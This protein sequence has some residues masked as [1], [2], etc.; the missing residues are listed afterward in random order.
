MANIDVFGDVGFSTVTREKSHPSFFLGDLDLFSTMNVDNRLIFLSEIQIEGEESRFFP[1]VERFWIGYTFNDLIT[2]RAGRHHTALGYWNNAYHHGKWLF[3]TVDRPFFLGFEDKNGVIPVHLIGIEME[4]KKA[5]DF[6]R[7]SYRFQIANGPRID[8][9][10]KKLDP[11]N[12]ADD[13]DSKEAAL[14]FSVTPVTVPDFIFGIS[15]TTYTLDTS[16]KAGLKESIFGFDLSYTKLPW[17]FLAEYFRFYNSD[18]A[19]DA[20]YIQLS[21]ALTLP[22]PI[23]PYARYERLG[24]NDSDPYFLDLAGGSERNQKI[25]GLKYEVDPFDS[26]IKLQYRNDDKKGAQTYHIVEIQWAVHF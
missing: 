4:G 6:G 11:N 17:E 1:E 18:A 20:F 2:L 19:A 15:G 9:I 14:R 13:N 23:T 21:Y 8:P 16:Q 3:V 12:I 10:E 7:F 25:M 5:N 22:Y 24:V 26:S